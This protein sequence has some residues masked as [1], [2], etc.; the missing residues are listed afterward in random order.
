MRPYSVIPF[1][2][3]SLVIPDQNFMRQL[4]KKAE[5]GTFIGV[6]TSFALHSNS[7]LSAE[8]LNG[9]N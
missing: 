4:Q 9:L 5:L 7:N 2:W 3:A 1:G 8:I 6:K